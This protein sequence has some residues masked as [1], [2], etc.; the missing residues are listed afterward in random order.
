MSEIDA[1]KEENSL[2]KSE[3]V[4]IKKEIQSAT[5]LNDKLDLEISVLKNKIAAEEKGS[6]QFIMEI[7]QKLENRVNFKHDGLFD[8]H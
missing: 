2:L 1:L 7:K 5:K 3:K 6:E 8:L 4:K